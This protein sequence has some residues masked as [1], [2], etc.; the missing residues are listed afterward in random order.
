MIWIF[1]LAAALV[2][3]T[4]AG[5]VGWLRIRMLWRSRCIVRGAITPPVSIVMVVRNEQQVLETKLRNLMAIDYPADR[6]QIVVVSDGSTDHT[7]SILRACGNDARIHI[8]LNQLAQGKACGLNDAI[9]VAQGEIVVFTDARQIIEPQ[10]VRLLAENFADPEV[11]CVSGELMLG[12]AGQA[13]SSEGLSLYWRIEK[14]VRK[15]EAATGSVVGA[16]GA[17][18][19]VRRELL[20]RVPPGTILDDVYLPMQVV[21]QGKRVILDER[22]RAWDHPNLGTEREFSRKVRTLSGNYQLLQLAPWLLSGSNP[23][24]FEFVSHKLLRLAV[25]FALVV[26]L[27]ASFAIRAPLYRVALILQLVFYALS[28]LAIGRWVKSGI[29]GRVADAAGTFVLLNGAAVVALANF[30]GGRRAAWTR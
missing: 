6:C 21:R 17:L 9:D 15:L 3:Y 2:A 16:T 8:V 1:W 19:A 24:R 22:A 4:Y 29:L 7:E 25:P 27:A 20:T 12:D 28:V 26:L 23:I 13:E 10:A 5:Y 30:V 18:Y 14:L 11:G